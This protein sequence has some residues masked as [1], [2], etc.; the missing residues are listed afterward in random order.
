MSKSVTGSKAAFVATST[1]VAVVDPAIAFRELSRHEQIAR[2][3]EANAADRKTLLSYLGI[4][5]LAS[6]AGHAALIGSSVYE[7]I[8][9]KLCKAFGRDWH[10][11]YT[12]PARDLSDAEKASKKE[13]VKAVEDIR[14]G[15]KTAAGNDA[16]KGSDAI[17]AIKDW[18]SG[19][20]QSKS[21]PKANEKR[22]T[23][24]WLATW[25]VL[26]SMY[27]RLMEAEDIGEPEQE[28][29]DAIAAYFATRGINEAHIRELKGKSE[30][31]MPTK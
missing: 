9:L 29:A 6:I 27:R 17:R 10:R 12:T 4:G 11:L 8:H 18:G 5:Q 21:N 15:V 22:D 20:R 14:E 2:I 30:Y 16:Q 7:A 26:P 13:L 24:T 1:A 3:A 25:D 19:K 23:R 28:L 31:V